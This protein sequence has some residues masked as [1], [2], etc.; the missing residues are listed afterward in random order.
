M[1]RAPI[2]QVARPLLYV[3]YHRPWFGDYQPGNLSAAS[4]HTPPGMEQSTQSLGCSPAAAPA[5]PAAPPAATRVSARDEQ[6]PGHAMIRVRETIVGP[7]KY[8]NVGE[9][10]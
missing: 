10:Q 5:A 9:S 3:N 7:G 2:K 4:S 1:H 8:S 6:R